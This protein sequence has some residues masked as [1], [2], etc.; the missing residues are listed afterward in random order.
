[1]KNASK[2]TI[3]FLLSI[4]VFSGETC[5]K[6]TPKTCGALQI[7]K[8]VK[9][10]TSSNTQFLV[11]SGPVASGSSSCE[12]KYILY[13]S[14][15]DTNRAETDSTM[16]PLSNLHYSFHVNSDNLYFPDAPNPVPFLDYGSNRNLTA[17][18]FYDWYIIFS[19]HNLTDTSASNFY[20]KTADS[21]AN[22]ADSIYVSGT[23]NYYLY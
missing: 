1:M 12:A 8:I 10:L 16:P 22:P 13:F 21:S 14:W 11:Q 23:V 9:T 15:A 3:G 17:D 2:I 20:I 6:V 18:R 19:E 5:P 7:A 4:L